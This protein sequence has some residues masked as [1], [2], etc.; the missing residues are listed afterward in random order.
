MPRDSGRAEQKND[1][2][3]VPQ[4]LSGSVFR[5]DRV[6]GCGPG[7]VMSAFGLAR[8]IFDLPGGVLAQR[9]NSL[10]GIA[11][12]VTLVSAGSIISAFASGYPALVL[13]RFVA[14]IG[15]AT[16][17]V[18]V[19]TH[20]N[21]HSD[22]T[23][24]GKILG[25]F[26][27]FFLGGIGIGPAV[28]GIIGARWGWRATFIFCAATALVALAAVLAAMFRPGAS[29][30]GTEGHTGD[31]KIPDEKQQGEGGLDIPAVVTVNLVTFIMLFAMEGFNNT[32]IP[33]YGSLVIGLQSDVLGIV[34]PWGFL[35][36]LRLA[37]WG[38]YFPTGTAG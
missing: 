22:Y 17:N 26:Q 37:C 4:L 35:P 31:K 10:T 21:R 23:N 28:G 27:G 29:G 19:L 11:I 1:C 3:T 14:G 7:L 24:R 16:T 36:G 33:L 12:G 25:I 34:L 5:T 2:F 6:G 30:A 13:G 20:L 38:G 8:L 15:S 32:I 9:L 18:V